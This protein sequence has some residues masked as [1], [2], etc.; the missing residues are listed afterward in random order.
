MLLRCLEQNKLLLESLRREGHHSSS[1]TVG[2]IHSIESQIVEIEDAL[3]SRRDTLFIEGRDF[4]STSSERDLIPPPPIAGSSIGC[5]NCGR[6]DHSI[7]E[8]IALAQ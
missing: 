2:Q 1:S 8:C 5:A 7:S 6:L 4:Q 3:T